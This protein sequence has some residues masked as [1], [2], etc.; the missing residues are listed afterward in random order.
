[1]R[2]LAKDIAPVDFIYSLSTNELTVNFEKILEKNILGG[3][4]KFY[5]FI[6]NFV[7]EY[8]KEIE[9]AFKSGSQQFDM[10]PRK[11]VDFDI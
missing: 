9:D 7:T 11:T 2:V 6:L 8:N 4:E 5:A 10:R 1:M 3:V